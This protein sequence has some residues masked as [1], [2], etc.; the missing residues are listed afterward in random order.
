VKPVQMLFKPTLFF[1]YYVKLRQYKPKPFLKKY[2]SFLTLPLFYF[3]LFYTTYLTGRYA[4]CQVF[5]RRPQFWTQLQLW[6][7]SFIYFTP[8][9][10]KMTHRYRNVLQH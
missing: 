1:T 6:T 5:K 8:P 10:L 7:S 2:L 9:T 3:V 4:L